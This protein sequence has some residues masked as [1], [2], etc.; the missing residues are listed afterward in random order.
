MSKKDDALSRLTTA[1]ARFASVRKQ[2]D[3][4]LRMLRAQRLQAYRGEVAHLALTAYAMGASM[5]EIKR[6]YGTKDHR[7]VSAIIHAGAAE[8]EAIRK[9]DAEE[10]ASN[11]WFVIDGDT[12]TITWEDSTAEFTRVALEDDEIMLS[13]EEPRWNEEYTVENK[14]VAKFDGM[15]SDELAE[16][17]AIRKAWE[18]A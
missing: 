5:G 8:I 16:V 13:T 12:V 2:I 4:E 7:T 6:A 9:A 10:A 3:E 17:E 18:A 15:T 1:R 14:A 11:T